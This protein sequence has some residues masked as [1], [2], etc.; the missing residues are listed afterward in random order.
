MHFSPAFFHLH[1]LRTQVLLWTVLPLTILL[2]VFSVSGVSSHQQ[3]MR[4]LSADE[5]ARLVMA[6]AQLV[7]LQAENTAL[8][9]HASLDQVSV[10]DL[11]LASLLDVQ[12][13]DAVVTVVLLDRTGKLLFGTGDVPAAN[14]LTNWPGASQALAGQSGVLFTDETNSGDVVAY[15]PVLSTGWVLLLR[16]PWHSLTDPLI[17]F[18]QIIPFVLL[19]AVVIS[20]LALFFGVRNVVQPLRELRLRANQIG[21]GQFDAAA[22]PVSGV[23]EIEALRVTLNDMAQRIRSDQASRQEYLGAV[24]RAQEEERVRIA[25]ELHDETVQTLIALGHKAQMAQRALARDPEQ[26][27]ARIGE[28][29]ELIAQAI[30]EV[31]RFSQA[32]HPYYLEE[33]GLVPALE[34][35]AHEAHA[36]FQV[37]G[38][39][40]RLKSD[41]ELALYRIAQEALNNARRHAQAPTVRVEISFEEQHVILVVRDDGHGF[42]VPA[43]LSHL[44]HSGHFGLIGMRE[45][46]QLVGGQLQVESQSASG[47][48]I[49]FTLDRW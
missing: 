7:G 32:L 18:E 38:S 12:H 41:N 3:S 49:T 15:A 31:R 2:I 16:E 14:T 17:R 25:R 10:S 45:R 11:P 36:D 44:T 19:T 35:L 23:T 9:E 33:L 5:N 28:L 8:R 13:A 26:T 42:A 1:G 47:T 4:A 40:Y 6:L 29:R 34:T 20:L 21:Q 22:Q 48:T 30:E 37:R 46:S 39:P 24:T 27:P 43:D